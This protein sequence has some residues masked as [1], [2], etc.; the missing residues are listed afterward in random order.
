MDL[1]RSASM[2]SMRMMGHFV[3][4]NPD[5]GLTPQDAELAM[6]SL[7][8]QNHSGPRF[9]PD[10]AM[11]LHFDSRGGMAKGTKSLIASQTL[12]NAT[13]PLSYVPPVQNPSYVPPINDTL[14]EVTAAGASYHAVLSNAT[15]PP[16]YVPP[17]RNPSYVPPITTT[18]LEP[19][20]TP[21]PQHE[22]LR[23]TTVEPNLRC[24]R[25]NQTLQS[26]LVAV[27]PN[28]SPQLSCREVE[29]ALTARRARHHVS[30]TSIRSPLT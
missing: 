17:P 14:P 28:R 8:T 13:K 5:E 25:R 29:Q 30:C 2:H 4:T 11:N 16:S 6:R 22:P 10:A 15:N 27:E 18:L 1:L 20:A 23:S 19:V 26:P 21:I 24:M 7:L 12:P 3:R 9:D